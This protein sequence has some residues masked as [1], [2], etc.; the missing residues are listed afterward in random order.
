MVA[1]AVRRRRAA[2]RAPRAKLSSRSSRMLAGG[3]RAAFVASCFRGALP[4]NDLTAC[5]LGFFV[6]APREHGRASRG[7][8]RAGRA[9]LLL[10]ALPSRRNA[11]CK[12]TS[13]VVNSARV[14][15]SRAWQSSVRPLCDLSARCGD[16][17]WIRHWRSRLRAREPAVLRQSIIVRGPRR[18]AIGCDLPRRSG[19]L[20]C[21]RVLF[22]KLCHAASH[23]ELREATITPPSL[24]PGPATHRCKP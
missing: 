10:R 9:R 14:A 5:S 19:A 6:D 20:F 8:E 24:W 23:P 2:P 18:V 1:R 17:L 3:A 22:A 4:K 13:A 12:S 15:H 21:N 7:R 16:A 11:A